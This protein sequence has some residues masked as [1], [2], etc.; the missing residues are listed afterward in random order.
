MWSLN[1]SIP[2]NSHSLAAECHLL[3]LLD[4]S[5]WRHYIPSECQESL[6]QQTCTISQKIHTLKY[7]II[8]NINP[9]WA[10]VTKHSICF[11]ITRFSILYTECIYVFHII[12]TINGNY[13]PNSINLFGFVMET[14]CLGC[15]GNADKLF[16]VLNYAPY[17]EETLEVWPHA[18][19][20]CSKLG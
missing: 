3:Q 13:F 4:A 8:L 20:T 17:S 7:A 16:P 18:F 11:N 6:T 2:I 15:S 10:V 12:P 9:L 5:S 19:S 14:A 1:S